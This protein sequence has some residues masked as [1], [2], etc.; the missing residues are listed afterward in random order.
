MAAFPGRSS[1][2]WENGKTISACNHQWI[3]YSRGTFKKLYDRKDY[4]NAG[5][6]LR[7][8]IEQC[9]GKMDS[10]QRAWI[11]NDLAITQFHLGDGLRCMEYAKNAKADQN[12]L[13]ANSGLQKAIETNESLC[14]NADKEFKL[15]SF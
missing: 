6:F 7:S 13:N 1:Y 12:L 5:D 4:V 2:L 10:T 3:E 8:V 9:D 15:P 14:K 11:Y